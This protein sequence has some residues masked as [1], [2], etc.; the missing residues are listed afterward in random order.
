M[1]SGMRFELNLRSKVGGLSG[2]MEL[3]ERISRRF[4]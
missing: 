2:K 4:I 3:R 1:R